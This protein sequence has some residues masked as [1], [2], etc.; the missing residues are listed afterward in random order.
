MTPNRAAHS[1][2]VGKSAEYWRAWSRVV[3]RSGFGSC[4]IAPLTA[5]VTVDP[6]V[7]YSLIALGQRSALANQE[8]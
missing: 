1:I 4:E 5:V 6:P 8:V 2:E 7:E 3:N